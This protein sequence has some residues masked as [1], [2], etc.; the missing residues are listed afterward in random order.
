M[1]RL[2]LGIREH[3]DA[4]HYL[5]GHES[6]G[7]MHGHTYR[8]EVV[9]EGELEGNILMDFAELRGVVREVLAEYDHA[10]LNEL[11]EY[12]SAENLCTQIFRKLRSRLEH[13]LRVRLWEG[14]GKWVQVE[15]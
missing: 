4:A 7:R 2:K 5:P 3:F 13:P 15:G 11:M 14:E 6:C 12:P 8:V 1:M 10:V 9:I